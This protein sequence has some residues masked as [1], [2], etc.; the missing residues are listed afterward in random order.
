[1]QVYHSAAESHPLLSNLVENERIKSEK[2][3]IH[4]IQVAPLNAERL[5]LYTLKCIKFGEICCNKKD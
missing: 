1:M 2:C 5:Q 3:Q 4:L